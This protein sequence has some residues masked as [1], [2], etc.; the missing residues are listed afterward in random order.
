MCEA[1]TFND[2]TRSR[3]KLLDKL[4]IVCA[5]G[6]KKVL[7]IQNKV[8]LQN[9]SIKVTEKNRKQREN[10]H[11]IRKR[12][13]LGNM[14]YI[15]NGF[16]NKLVVDKLPVGSNS[17]FNISQVYVKVTFLYDDDILGVIVKYLRKE[18]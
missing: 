6:S 7:A 1:I 12:K 3:Q 16:S 14:C 9:A 15:P 8:W 13:K 10:L 18:N 11:R 5:Q 17:D 2:G 4:K